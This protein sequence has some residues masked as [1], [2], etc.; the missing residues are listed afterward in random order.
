MNVVVLMLDSL[1]PDYVACGGH[2]QIRTPHIDSVAAEG[3]LLDRAYAEYPITIP[4]RTALVTGCY[5]WTNRPWQSLLPS[6]MH[7]AEVLRDHGYATAAFSDGPFNATSDMDRGFDDFWWTNTGKCVGHKDVEVDASDAWFAPNFEGRERQYYGATLQGRALAMEKYGQ[8]C[9]E[10]LFDR[11][12]K[13]LDGA[14]GQSQPFFLW[15][16]SFQPHEPWAPVSPYDEMY[17]ALDHHRYIPMPMGP[18]ITWAED[19]D[20]DHIRRLYMSEATHAD[21]MVGMV[22]DRLETLGLSEDTLLVILSDHG[23]PL[24]E[25]A[26]IRKFYVPLYEELARTMWIMRKPG[27]IPA[28]MRTDAL[29]Q[30]TDFPATILDW[31][32]VTPPPRETSRGFQGVSG[33]EEMDGVSLAGLL[34]GETDRVHDYLY[35]GAFGLRA[36][37]LSDTHKLID[38]QGEKPDELFDMRADPAELNDLMADEPDL[39]AELYHHLWDFRMKWG[40][41]L[42]WRDRPVRKKPAVEIKGGRSDQED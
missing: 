10:L 13:W 35:N 14:A 30:N 9:P 2:P 32:G 29:V 23:E 34:S 18:D 28:G 24:G 33:K 12:L 6:D 4:A 11:A 15:V 20:L 22:V 38:H 8:H 27:L 21:D 7:I 25:H 36:S 16:D 31:C 42:R 17:G 3:V 41:N 26:Q 1:R 39:A 19:G 37:I 40:S 5:T